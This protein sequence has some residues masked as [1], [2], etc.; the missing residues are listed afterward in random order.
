M[1][2]RESVPG[3]GIAILKRREQ[4]TVY[5]ISY[6]Q[7]Q[8][9]GDITRDFQCATQK[10]IYITS[11]SFLDPLGYGTPVFSIYSRIHLIPIHSALFHA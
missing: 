3:E 4:K 5:R 7:Q 8:R 11:R 9:C 6:Q 1:K 10:H 2:R